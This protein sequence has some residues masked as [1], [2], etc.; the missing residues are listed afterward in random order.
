VLESLPY[1]DNV[2]GKNLSPQK[3]TFCVKSEAV[4][5]KFSRGDTCVFSVLP[6]EVSRTGALGLL[7]PKGM[8]RAE[9][10]SI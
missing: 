10:P 4:A 9:A 6:R 5:S 1:I 2:Y 7:V 8:R 3:E